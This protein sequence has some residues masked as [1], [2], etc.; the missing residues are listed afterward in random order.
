[1]SRASVPARSR[2]NEA[3]AVVSIHHR[4][5][6]VA[7]GAWSRAALRTPE[8]T[9]TFGELAGGSDRLA[10]LLGELGCAR[11]DRIAILAS[12]HAA[13]VTAMLGVLKAGCVFAPLDV[14]VPGER[15]AALLGALSCRAIV[16]DAALR[17]RIP[18]GFASLP[19]VELDGAAPLSAP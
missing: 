2:A 10:A 1:M 11:C 5:D 16:V 4:F 8:R 9:T 19:V 3:R 12:D 14:A 7:H 17:A 18:A 6:R 13:V 15:L